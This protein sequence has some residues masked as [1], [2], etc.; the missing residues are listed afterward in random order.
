MIYYD[1]PPKIRDLKSRFLYSYTISGNLSDKLYFSNE[2]IDTPTPNEKNFVGVK[3][4]KYISSNKKITSYGMIPSESGIPFSVL[5]DSVGYIKTMRT[6]YNLYGNH[7]YCVFDFAKRQKLHRVSFPKIK[8][9]ISKLYFNRDG[10]LYHFDCNN[11][12]H[13]S[14]KHGEFAHDWL[15]THGYKKEDIL[16]M[17]PDDYLIMKTEMMFSKL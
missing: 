17:S 12:G 14:I 13:F 16:T 11:N 6:T 3:V 4:E 9:G 15:K 7:E 8:N 5:R 10:Q 1:K 2:P